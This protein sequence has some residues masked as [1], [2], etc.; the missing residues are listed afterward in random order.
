MLGYRRD[1]CRYQHR[2]PNTYRFGEI[3]VAERKDK[4]HDK[5]TYQYPYYRVIEIPE[6][7]PDE[8][9]SLFPRQNVCPMK[10]SRLFD[11]PLCQPRMGRCF[12]HIHQIQPSFFVRSLVYLYSRRRTNNTERLA[13]FCRVW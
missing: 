8:G 4:V 11:L 5:R 1:Q 2:S 9:L 6:K 12:F 10:A 3:S 13:F 7:A